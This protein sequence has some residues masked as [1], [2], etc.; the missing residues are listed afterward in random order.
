[1]ACVSGSVMWGE[2]VLKKNLELE[3]LVAGENVGWGCKDVVL[4]PVQFQPFPGI[5]PPLRAIIIE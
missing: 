1:M 5:R 3:M 4:Y 2:L